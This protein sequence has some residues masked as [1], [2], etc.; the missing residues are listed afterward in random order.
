MA[1]QEPP[2]H[3]T[4]ETASP[5]AVA[6]VEAM[7]DILNIEQ[8]EP[9]VFVGQSPQTSWQRVFGGQV[10]GQALVAAERTVDKGRTPHSLHAYFLR[11]G[12]TQHPITYKVENLRDG[13]SFSTRRVTALQHDVA[14]YAMIAN[15]QIEETGLDFMRPMPE[16]PQPE[17]L[18]KEA[19]FRQ[20]FLQSLPEPARK[21]FSEPRPIEFRPLRPLQFVGME[22][23]PERAT[24]F[25]AASPLG[26][27]PAIHRCVL[28]YASDMTLLDTAI[29]VHGK[30]VFSPDIQA[31]S[32]DHVIWFHR[33]F[34]ADDWLL[35]EQKAI[36]TIGARGLAHGYIY[37]QQGE[38]VASVAQ[39]GLIRP[40]SK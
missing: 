19:E 39:E 33:P 30:S 2:S 14:I 11:A 25:R 37:N 3:A 5:Q 32:L 17:K 1:S 23:S 20:A 4:F 16:S 7:L 27:D 28:A 24:W 12:D 9:F 36:N 15:F 34:R 10:V 40:I 21:R 22:A 6:A 8:I 35:Y 29:A 13:R 31:A 18:L 26:D 38:L